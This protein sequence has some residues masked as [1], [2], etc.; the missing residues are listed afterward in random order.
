MDN[1]AVILLWTHVLLD[2]E[3]KETKAQMARLTTSRK[4][5]IGQ[6]PST[7]AYAHSNWHS[8]NTGTGTDALKHELKKSWLVEAVD[9]DDVMFTPPTWN[10][11]CGH[12]RAWRWPGTAGWST[13][14]GGA[15]G[16]FCGL[17]RSPAH[18]MQSCLSWGVEQ[19]QRK[20]AQT[21]T[22]LHLPLTAPPRDRSEDGYFLDITLGEKK[23]RHQVHHP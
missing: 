19:Q 1:K 23:D 7:W 5:K 3:Q 8:Q 13:P 16:W 15:R 11:W 17:V 22:G 20:E 9:T 21:G 2:S 6:C 4:K 14:A 12:I 10:R 18:W